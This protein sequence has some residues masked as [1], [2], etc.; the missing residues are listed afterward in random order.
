MLRSVWPSVCWWYAVDNIVVVPISLI[1]FRHFSVLKIL[2][3]S[4]VMVFGIPKIASI[5]G[6]WFECHYVSVC[7][8]SVILVAVIPYQGTYVED[9]SVPK[10]PIAIAGPGEWFCWLCDRRIWVYR[11]CHM[12]ILVWWDC[13]RSVMAEVTVQVVSLKTCAISFL[14]TLVD[15][16]FA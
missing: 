10:G 8:S 3:R 12:Q 15:K 9:D 14:S 5:L 11:A 16:L 6:S 7:V 2:S 13:R 4:E 1:R